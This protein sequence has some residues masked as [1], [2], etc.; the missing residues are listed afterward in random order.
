VRLGAFGADVN[1]V[2]A[3]KWLLASTS[4]GLLYVRNSSA[5]ALVTPTLPRRRLRRLLCLH[6]HHTPA[7]HR[8]C[9]RPRRR[10]RQKVI[11]D[12][13][14]CP[15]RNPAAWLRPSTSSTCPLRG[16]LRTVRAQ[17]AQ[18]SVRRRE[19]VCGERDSDVAP[20]LQYSTTVKTSR[21]SSQDSLSCS[22]PDI[23]AY[24]NITRW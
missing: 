1:T 6:R 18:G 7:S 9:R 2:S 22:S 23:A 16:A 8:H 3:H 5:Q 24:K 14:C 15:Y 11:Q 20:L 19:P 10:E 12:L 4:S 13:R 21:S 17:C